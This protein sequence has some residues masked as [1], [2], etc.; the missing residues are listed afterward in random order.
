MHHIFNHSAMDLAPVNV[1]HFSPCLTLNSTLL[2]CYIPFIQIPCLS[3]SCFVLCSISHTHTPKA[4]LINEKKK[5][6]QSIEYSSSFQGGR[7]FS[8]LMLIKQQLCFSN[9]GR[10]EGGCPGVR[11]TQMCT[12][13]IEI[14]TQRKKKRYNGAFLILNLF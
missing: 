2:L 12:E 8:H 9:C 6:N 7:S 14:N 11:Q 10:R 5:K 4:R 1:A 3:P 13:I